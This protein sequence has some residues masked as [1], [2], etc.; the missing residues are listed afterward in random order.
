MS[1]SRAHGAWWGSFIGDA[2]AMPAHWYYSR[3]L[4]ARDYGTLDSYKPPLP[5]HPDSILWRSHYTATGPKDDILHD[6]ARFWGL[7]DIH[8]HQFLQAGENTLNL[9]LAAVL[10]ESLI[11]CQ[12]YDRNDF[13]QRYLA[14]M[15]TPGSHRDT[16]VEEFHR[17]F[18]QNHAKGKKPDRCG[19]DD[20]HIGGLAMVVPLVLWYLH[21]DEKLLQ[22]VQSHVSL[23]H[24]NAQVQ[25]AA[26]TFARL[27]Q[28]FILGENWTSASKNLG[29]A[30]HP[31]LEHPYARW[32][33]E[34]DE[35][36]V[37]GSRFST[38]CYIGDAFPAALFLACKYEND[39]RGAIMANT[40]LGGDN[41]HR[42]V[43][44]GALTGARSGKEG[45]PPEW[46]T[47]LH[48]YPR[49]AGL[50]ADFPRPD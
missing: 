15:L 43:V 7:K 42:G 27:L 41:C 23:T 29:P 19:I 39:P 37:V 50:L 20:I 38:A 45:L 46:I 49:L 26:R 17:G 35:S 1:V 40:R 12:G 8:Y 16:Y 44:V 48:D 4:I 21:D 30:A 13:V 2:L 28:A 25:D 18:F 3:A 47:G 14:F 33:R 32:A 36:H 24:K 6:Q 10:A 34:E 31:A 9:K 22:A 11:S 5:H